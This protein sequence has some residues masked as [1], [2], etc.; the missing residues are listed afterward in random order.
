MQ[1]FIKNPYLPE[2]RVNTVIISRKYKKIVNEIEKLKIKCILIEENNDLPPFV[3]Q[4]ADM[5]VHHLKDNE[6]LLFNYDKKLNETLTDLGFKLHFSNSK[7]KKEYPYDIPLNCICLNNVLFCNQKYTD[8]KILDFNKN[9]K[10]I[11]TKQGYVKCSCVLVSNTHIITSDKNIEK[12]MIQ[13]G[14]KV[15]YVDPKNI[16]LE[17]YDNGFIGG[18]ASLIDKNKL[19]FT[20]NLNEHKNKIVDFCKSVNVDVIELPF[21]KLTDIGSIIPILQD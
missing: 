6:I 10:I 1:K 16:V 9:A 2:S 3:N 14:F 5:L 20:G 19:L 21:K 18:C 17:G 12:H 11:N 7:L 8:T 15:L 13:N 4:H